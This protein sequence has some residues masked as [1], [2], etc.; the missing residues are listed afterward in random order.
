MLLDHLRVGEEQRAVMERR[1][2]RPEEQLGR[3][4]HVR[5]LAVFQGVAQDQ[6][7]E[8]VEEERRHLA[9]ALPDEREISGLEARGAEKRVAEAQ[10]QGP[11]LARVGVGERGDLGRARPAVAGPP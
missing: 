6:V 3:A 5:V 2:L 11:V 1:P 4:Q 9:R 7:D 10:H 8:L